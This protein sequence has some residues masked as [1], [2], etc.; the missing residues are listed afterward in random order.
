MSRVDRERLDDI[1]EAIAA[2]GRHL[3]RGELSDGPVVDAVRLRLI[4]IGEAVKALDPSLAARE[5]PTP[6]TDAAGMRDRLTRHSFDT[7]RSV[8]EATVKEDLPGLEAAARRL[9]SELPPDAQ[10]T[11]T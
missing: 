2:I 1:P 5:S 3:E 8:I 6:W 11:T 9:R 4:E 10:T 7:S